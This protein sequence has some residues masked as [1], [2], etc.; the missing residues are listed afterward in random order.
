MEMTSA[1]T[2]AL[3]S[4]VPDRARDA[5][6]RDVLLSAY[7][8]GKINRQVVEAATGLWFGE[9]LIELGKRGLPPPR[10]DSTVHFNARQ[11]ELY[12]RI[13]G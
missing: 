8:D 10:V 3:A 11:R 6:D 7:S 4:P 2:D 1:N 13:F 5:V 9:I 12:Q